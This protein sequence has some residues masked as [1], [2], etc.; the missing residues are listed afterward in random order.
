MNDSFNRSTYVPDDKQ[1]TRTHAPHPSLSQ[2]S[3]RDAE[4]IAKER[5]I[6]TDSPLIN[7]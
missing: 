5:A 7:P 2:I 3:G 1:S 4:Q 6:N